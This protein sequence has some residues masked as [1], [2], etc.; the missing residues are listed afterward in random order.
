M[1]TADRGTKALVACCTAIFWPGAFIFGF[2]GVMGSVWQQKFAVGQ[3][4]VGQTLFFVLAAVGLFMFLSSRLLERFGPSRL[5][6]VGAILGGLSTAWV[7]AAGR[8]IEVYAWAFLMGA[9]STCIYLPTL[10]IVQQWYPTRRGL[11]SGL[12]N[13]FFGFSAA[14][15]SP[16]FGWTL[17]GIGYR[18]TALCFGLLAVGVGLAA[19]RFCVRPAASRPAR[20]GGGGG[21]QVVDRSLTVR[22]SLGTRAFWSLWGVWAMA[23]A[24]GIAMV[25]LSTAFGTARGLNLQEAIV[26][27]TAFNI[28]NGSSRLVSGYI[29]DRFSRVQ[30]MSISFAGAGA[31]YL[32]IS[33]AEGLLAWS[34]LAA[35]VGFAFGALFA[36]SAPLA[37]DVFGLRNFGT[38]FGL[39]FTAYGFVAGLLGPWLSGF[40]LDR[41]GGDFDPVFTYLGIFLL[42]SSGL[43]Q[44]V[45]PGET[46]PAG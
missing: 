28:T 9:A 46:A 6:A 44:F 35:V 16:V 15:M 36:V 4:A 38:I 11:V 17:Q 37:T 45:R 22:E 25:P 31:A 18:K 26:I 12:V 19:A 10:T 42:V 21:A 8:M 34:F 7:G 1:K 13:L 32:F 5:V 29:S 24:A 41:T 39:V 43:V 23:G 2:P 40:L 14:L 20:A 27:L 3:A 33:H 30:T